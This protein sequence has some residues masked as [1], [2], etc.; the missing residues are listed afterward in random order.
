MLPRSRLLRTNVNESGEQR[1]RAS[2]IGVVATSSDLGSAG[3][4]E[5]VDSFTGR[6]RAAPRGSCEKVI[7]ACGQPGSPPGMLLR[8]V[9]WGLWTG[10]P[11]L[12]VSMA[13]M[14]FSH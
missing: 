14:E 6:S 9:V 7:H 10:I 11:E 5:T 3:T 2:C 1:D 8:S 13:D 12:P 4:F